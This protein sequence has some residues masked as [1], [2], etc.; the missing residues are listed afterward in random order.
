VLQFQHFPILRE[1]LRWA[2]YYKL[3]A[4]PNGF[5]EL[6]E[7]ADGGFRAMNATDGTW[8]MFRNMLSSATKI[9][10][11]LTKEHL[12]SEAIVM[13]VAGTDTTASAL[14]VSLH[15]LLQQP[16]TYRKLQDEVRTVMPTLDS[17]PAIEELD[18][19][20]FLD[21]CIKEGLR[22]SCPSR[23]RMPRT[24]PE[25]GWTFKGQYFPAGVRFLSF[26]FNMCSNPVYRKLSASPRCI[27]CR[28]R[29]YSPLHSATTLRGGSLTTTG[30][31]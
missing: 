28:M 26:P 3:T 21:A 18:A 25:G 11:V 14:A 30:G 23:V 1:A 9:S 17:R 19:L 15:H 4:V 13:I 8:T 5:L 24:V 10:T 20:P 27:S 7:A 6:G 22:I 2:S 12:I 29:P 16:E 31:D